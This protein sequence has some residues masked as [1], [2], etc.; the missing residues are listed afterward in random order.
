M[1]QQNMNVGY[2]GIMEVFK[3]KERQKHLTGRFNNFIDST[4]GDFKR[5]NVNDYNEIEDDDD[6]ITGRSIC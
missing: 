5:R 6:E 4:N 2:K 1:M 3:Q